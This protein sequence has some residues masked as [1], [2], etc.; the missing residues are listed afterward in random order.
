[1]EANTKM[2]DMTQGS[3]AKHIFLFSLPLLLGNVLQQLYNMV[4]SWPSKYLGK[5]QLNAGL[6][7]SPALL[8]LSKIMVWK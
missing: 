2:R 5:Y 4:D 3:P 7:Y 6:I 1:M 8:F